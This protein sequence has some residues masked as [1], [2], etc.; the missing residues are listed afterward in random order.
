VGT[1]GPIQNK[2]AESTDWIHQH[3]SSPIGSHLIL[4]GL[5]PVQAGPND[6]SGRESASCRTQRRSVQQNTDRG[7]F[8]PLLTISIDNNAPSPTILDFGSAILSFER[9]PRCTG[10]D[11][12][13][14]VRRSRLD[15][16]EA[17]EFWPCSVERGRLGITKDRKSI[18]YQQRRS[19]G[20]F[21]YLL[22]SLFKSA[23]LESVSAPGINF[24]DRSSLD[25][26]PL[27]QVSA[28][29]FEFEH[30]LHR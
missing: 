18:H 29:Q 16:N 5:S 14:R 1:G 24:A 26:T 2:G 28:L 7:N 30:H 19:G 23:S 15:I 6:R 12:N 3:G 8:I 11:L 17:D 21:M 20:N 13:R 22:G 27:L 9:C 25:P 10:S 4:K